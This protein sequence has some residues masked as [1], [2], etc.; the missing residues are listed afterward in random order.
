[1]QQYYPDYKPYFDII[2]KDLAER[3]LCTTETTP[4]IIW[5]NRKHPEFCQLLKFG[6][7]IPSRIR[8]CVQ[9]VDIRIEPMSSAVVQAMLKAMDLK[10]NDAN[11]FCNKY[12]VSVK[13]IDDKDSTYIKTL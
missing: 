12:I 7:I 5:I 8:I 13:P 9:G 4:D 11:V 1:M 6:S 3:I 2:R 10:D